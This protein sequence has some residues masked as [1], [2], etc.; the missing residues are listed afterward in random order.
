MLAHPKDVD[1]ALL[2]VPVAADAFEHARAVVE[3]VGHYAYF[4]LTRR[5]ELP[6]EEHLQ[7][8][9]IEGSLAIGSHVMPPGA[10]DFRALYR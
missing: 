9:G 3:G 8:V 1:G 5:Y 10:K 2:G 7:L 6:A 4:G